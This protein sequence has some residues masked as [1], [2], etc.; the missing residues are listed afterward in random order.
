MTKQEKQFILSQ[1]TQS[2][3]DWM[4]L[5]ETFA[6]D[7][8]EPVQSNDLTTQILDYLYGEIAHFINRNLT[9]SEQGQLFALQTLLGWIETQLSNKR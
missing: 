8:M 7:D 9:P 3:N 1:Y 2:F 5:C 4:Q 6:T